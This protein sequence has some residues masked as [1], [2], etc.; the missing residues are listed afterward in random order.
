MF[1]TGIFGE[2]FLNFR[3]VTTKFPGVRLRRVDVRAAPGVAG[4]A[5]R[6]FRFAHVIIAFGAG[7]ERIMRRD[8][9]DS[10]PP[11]P[12]LRTPT[13]KYPSP[14]AHVVT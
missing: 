5:R 14:I 3:S 1:L 12:A 8:K 6:L 2:H 7:K 9:M 4:M 10:W 11:L 13:L